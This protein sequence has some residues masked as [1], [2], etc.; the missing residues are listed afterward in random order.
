M[1]GLF[2][3]V[4]F[5]ANPSLGKISRFRTIFHPTFVGKNFILLSFVSTWLVTA[6]NKGIAGEGFTFQR[7]S[8]GV[9]PRLLCLW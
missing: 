5:E 8:F 2:L 1:M 9:S 7:A 6:M 3:W 4:S